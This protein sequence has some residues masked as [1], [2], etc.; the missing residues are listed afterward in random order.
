MHNKASEVYND[1]LAIYFD[2][3]NH[4][5]VAKQKNRAQI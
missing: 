2:E 5:P 1:L 3:Y 4:L